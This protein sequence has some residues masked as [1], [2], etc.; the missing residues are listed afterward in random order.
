MVRTQQAEEAAKQLRIQGAHAAQLRRQLPHLQ[1]LA[2]LQV[3]WA[4]AEDHAST[5]AE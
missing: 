2:D 4:P 5:S 1:Q 3:R